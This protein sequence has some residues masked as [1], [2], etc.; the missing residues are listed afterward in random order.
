[1]SDLVQDAGQPQTYESDSN[2]IVNSDSDQR[3]YRVLED[4]KT[5]SGC[6]SIYRSWDEN[7]RPYYH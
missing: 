2:C 4:Q 7:S 5:D 1:M 6:Q 3:T